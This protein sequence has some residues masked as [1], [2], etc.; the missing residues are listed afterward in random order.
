MNV[1]E[2]V[3]A[4]VLAEL[5]AGTVPWV[6][7][8]RAS[9]ATGPLAVNAVSGA[10]YRGINPWLLVPPAGAAVNRWLTYRQ[11]AAAGGHVR[12]GEKGSMVVFFK[13][14]SITDK[15]AA[16][17]SSG[18]RP[19]RTIPLLRYF[20]VFHV[21]QCDG[22]PA[23]I[24]GDQEGQEGS[25]APL[26]DIERHAMAEKMLALADVR[27]GGNRAFYMP[28]PDAIQLPAPTAFRSASDYYATG[29]H[30]L[31]HWTGHA[32]RL[33]REYG[34]RF[35]DTAYA[36]E[37][38]VAEMGAAFLCAAAGIPGQLQ[39][40]SYIAS[41]ISVLKSD[42]RAIVV[43]AGAAQKAADYVLKGAGIGAHGETV[44]DTEEETSEA[45]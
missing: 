23:K 1:Y 45:A 37:E 41:W 7:P 29:L 43:A 40:A 30:E 14:W 20:T 39:H 38:L 4:K 9:G 42:S 6:R 16:P 5:E 26:T 28:G 24:L 15:N 31:T 36:R 27:H 44:T 19:N 13:P 17:D 3:T 2:I 10:Q 21:S 11:A 35:G 22:L 32:S 34:K 12:K 33:A 25:G 18:Q 8:W